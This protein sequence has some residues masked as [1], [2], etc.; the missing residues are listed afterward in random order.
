MS[1]NRV[2]GSSEQGFATKL[3]G[4]V[5]TGACLEVLDSEGVV[6]RAL[7]ENGVFDRVRFRTSQL[8]H[9]PTIV[10]FST[11]GVGVQHSLSSTLST[12]PPSID[13]RP[14]SFGLGQNT[15]L[16]CSEAVHLCS[17][18]RRLPPPPTE[19]QSLTEI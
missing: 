8:G 13:E 5:M 12:T 7:G 16:R 19:I 14:S 3:F 10:R 2:S 9:R 4:F 15:R 1:V 17:G 6:F 18:N 11:C